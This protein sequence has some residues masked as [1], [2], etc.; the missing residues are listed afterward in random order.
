MGL[1]N[2][3]TLLFDL[4]GTLVDSVPDL[5][6]AVNSALQQINQPQRSESEVRKWVG[7][8]V[9]RLLHR[10]LTG[11]HNGCANDTLHQQAKLEFNRW[12][13]T[14]FANQSQLY[15]SVAEVLSTLHSRGFKLGCVTNKPEQFTQSILEKLGIDRFFQSVIG[16]DST[17]SRKP[18]PLPL[19]TA[20]EQLGSTPAEAIMI[21]DSINDFEAGQRAGLATVMVSWGY[22]QGVD[23]AAL[24][25]DAMIDQFFSLIELLPGR[26][27]NS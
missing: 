14:H 6:D 25:A 16:G 1:E 4:D 13:G 3:N 10:A 20:L 11:Q 18:D 12:Y 27:G 17:R 9:D 19:L 15:E 5:T 26:A 21:G 22:H 8:G 2:I 24:E 7:N 23:L